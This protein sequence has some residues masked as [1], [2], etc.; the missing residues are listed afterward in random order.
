MWGTHLHDRT[1]GII[2]DGAGRII[3]LKQCIIA[4]SQQNTRHRPP[5]R[6]V[7]SKPS[8][9]SSH[10][11]IPAMTFPTEHIHQRTHAP[12]T[13]PPPSPSSPCLEK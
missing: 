3:T 9:T 6:V 1:H 10:K 2:S 5:I 13:S 11:P 8:T 4:K 7:D 12:P